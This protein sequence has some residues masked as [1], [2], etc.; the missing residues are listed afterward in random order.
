MPTPSQ[1]TL[2]QQYAAIVKGLRNGS[3]DE[4]Q[5]ARDAMALPVPEKT[6]AQPAEET[7]VRP[8]ADP[9]N[10]NA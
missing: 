2:G 4:Q 1:E 8:P 7:I 3:L 5:A 6:A 10:P 9:S